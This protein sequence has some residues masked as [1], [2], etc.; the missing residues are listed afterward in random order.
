MNSNVIRKWIGI[1]AIAAIAT[2]GF[3]FAQDTAPAPAPPDGDIGFMAFGTAPG[4]GMEAGEAI[5]V[6]GFEGGV[7]GKTVTG[8]PFSATFS[9]QTTQTLADGNQIKRSTSGTFA[10]DSE[11]RT[12]RD[13]TL[14]G[15]GP[16]A[17]SGKSAPHAVMINDV[18][19]G[20]QYILEPN[21]K[22][23]RQVRVLGK[24]RLDREGT[25]VQVDG[26][27]PGPPPPPE[28]LQFPDSGAARPDAKDVVTTSLGAQTINGV[29]AEGTRYTRTIPAGAIGNEKP[30]VITSERWYSSDLQMVVLSRRDDPRMGETVTQLT[31]IQRSEPDASLFQVPPDY[32][33]RHGGPN[34]RFRT[35]G[36]LEQ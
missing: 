28:A 30:I 20:K 9:T 13:L 8:A 6:V 3:A 22:V 35:R 5:A 24:R 7:G 33:V 23:A 18:V 4:P 21:R 16:W 19:A 14:P 2:P 17:A 36:R 11:G 34:V 32:K 27:M 12:R 31:N 15:I 29:L 1:L 26:S 10:R 25:S